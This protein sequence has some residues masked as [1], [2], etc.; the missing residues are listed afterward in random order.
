MEV[1]RI[2][3]QQNQAGSP[4]KEGKNKVLTTRNIQKTE[5]DDV[6]RQ[7]QMYKLLENELKN[8]MLKT[9]PEDPI[10]EIREVIA[11]KH[12]QQQIFRKLQEAHP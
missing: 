9:L 1:A 3:K 11:Q 10:A 8:S 4:K 6:I 2:E 5:Y 12:Q 7:L